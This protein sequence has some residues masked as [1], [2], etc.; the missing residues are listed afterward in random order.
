MAPKEDPGAAIP[1]PDAAAQSLSEKLALDSAKRA[2]AQLKKV[3]DAGEPETAEH[4]AKFMRVNGVQSVLQAV[5]TTVERIKQA[6]RGTKTPVQN[7]WDYVRAVVNGRT[8]RATYLYTLLN[9]WETSLRS[10]IELVIEAD[11]GEQWFRDPGAYLNDANAKYLIEKHDRA[12]KLFS[13][14]SSAKH[15]MAVAATIKYADGLLSELHLLTLHNI[16]LDNWGLFG[17]ALSAVLDTRAKTVI[18]LHA[19]YQA[20]LAV[21]HVREIQNVFFRTSADA[22]RALLE[23]LEFDVD[24]T[25]RAIEKRDPH[26]ED[27]ELFET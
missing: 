18:R 24:K 26:K 7:P 22:L 19:A 10:R 6:E 25:L 1:T 17:S 5:N 8:A 21:M 20:R 13:A 4:V 14:S 12:D 23:S 16:I 2:L 15:G 11:R 9:L 27:F 3:S